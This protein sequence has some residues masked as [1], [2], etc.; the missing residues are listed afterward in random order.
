[1]FVDEVEV[2]FTAGSG[3]AGKVSF[4]PG[5]RTG[6]DGGNGGKGGNIYLTVTSDLTSLNQFMGKKTRRAEDGQNGG[7]FNKTGRNGKD[8][9]IAL[10]QGSIIT[11]QETNEAIELSNIE[12][13]VLICKGGKGGQGTHD[14]T[15]PTN[16][17]P[18][19]AE[20]GEPGQ[21]KNL[22]IV[23]KL[24][25]DYGLIGLPNAGK[26]SLLNELTCANVK[27]ADYPFTTIE[28]NLGVMAKKIIADIP[29]LIEGASLGK[30]L[31]ISF[32]KH[33]EKVNLILH[34]VS[35]ESKNVLNDY[36]TVRQELQKFNPLLIQKSE[37]ILLTKSDLVAK[38]ELK[39]KR[40]MLQKFGQVL[41][42]SI[43]DDKSIKKLKELLTS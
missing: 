42:I 28:P 14:L 22:K 5:E 24:I 38:E 2:I 30:G 1:M 41:P 8:I 34:C 36:Q 9:T 13:K 16:T 18:L 26:S 3:G 35:V 6:P 10:P 29:G 20:A 25:A 33:I 31:G 43:L 21:Q 19:K 7:K 17:T 12:Q 23:L 15:S 37:I 11:D 32:L 40:K 4:Y 39:E 27:V